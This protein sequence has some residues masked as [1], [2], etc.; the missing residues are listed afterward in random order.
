MELLGDLERFDTFENTISSFNSVTTLIEKG[1][2]LQ[3]IQSKHLYLSESLKEEMKK[4]HT[5]HIEQ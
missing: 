4:P 2:R 5:G 1:R 3:G